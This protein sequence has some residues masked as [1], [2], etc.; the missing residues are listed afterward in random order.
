MAILLISGIV[1][2]VGMGWG[3]LIHQED[4][5]EIQTIR[6]VGDKK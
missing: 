2:S 3:A 6:K 4:L 1:F 5:L